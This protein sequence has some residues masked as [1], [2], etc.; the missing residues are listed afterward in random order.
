MK[1]LLAFIITISCA[2]FILAQDI[3]VLKSGERIENV[4]V[5]SISDTTITYVTNGREHNVSNTKVGAI[6]Y[7]DGR[8]VEMSNTENSLSINQNEYLLPGT[9]VRKGLT[10]IGVFVDTVNMIN[11]K[12]VREQAEQ[13]YCLCIAEEDM[14]AYKNFLKEHKDIRKQYNKV[15]KDAGNYEAALQASRAYKTKRTE[16]ASSE[17]ACAALINTFIKNSKNNI[18]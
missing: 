18:N 5:S 7:A 1:R 10:I 8:Y 9:D 11:P 2:G 3:V 6:L 14:S 4:I 12:S 16:G 15:F 13:Y 17:E